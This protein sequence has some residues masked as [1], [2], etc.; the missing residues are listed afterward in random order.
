MN[1]R[2]LL[3][4]TFVQKKQPISIIHLITRRCNARCK[5]CFIDF[6]DPLSFEKELSIEEIA[7]LTKTFG[8]AL[9]SVYISGGEPFLR[10]DIFEIVSAYCKDTAVESVNIATNGM[11]TK[12]I[13][14]FIDK[15]RAAGLGKRLM[16]SISIDDFEAQ[17][18]S[19][20][21]APGLYKNA[22]ASYKLIDSYGDKR[23][24]P[25]VAITVTSYNYKNVVDVYRSLK[26]NGLRAFSAILMREQ[27]VV[28]I[29]E[30]SSKCS[31]HMVNSCG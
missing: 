24:F 27:G 29:I 7:R 11:H 30:E 6:N 20:R 1:Y 15:F 25:A 8:D 19:N 3:F 12:A 22:I 23:I 17:H 4:N 28:K 10:K 2:R 16:I 31:K 5:H 9:Y 18:D 14:V 26:T 21:R 13:G